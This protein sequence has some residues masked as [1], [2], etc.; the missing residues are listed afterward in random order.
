MAELCP[1][2]SSSANCQ[3]LPSSKPARLTRTLTDGHAHGSD[4]H[5]RHG[6]CPCES[7]RKASPLT[8]FLSANSAHGRLTRSSWPVRERKAR[9]LDRLLARS[10]SAATAQPVAKTIP[11]QHRPY[12]SSTRLCEIIQLTAAGWSRLQAHLDRKVLRS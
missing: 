1:K 6:H 5:E 11:A 3:R 7:A 9:S 8:R 12:K 10:R 4:S 2:Y